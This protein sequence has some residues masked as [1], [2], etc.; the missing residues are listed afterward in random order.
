MTI[1]C[2]KLCSIFSLIYTIRIFF[3]F[4]H[5]H[6]LQKTLLNIGISNITYAE[7]DEKRR[8]TLTASLFLLLFFYFIFFTSCR[9][10]L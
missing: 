1:L 4:F 9:F 5:L 2:M 7:V 8:Q 3:F 10:P 6:D